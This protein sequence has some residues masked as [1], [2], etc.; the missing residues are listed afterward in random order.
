MSAFYFVEPNDSLFVR[1]NQAFG[2]AGEY[3]P[4]LMPPPPSLFA[5]AFRAAILGQDPQ[6]LGRFSTTGATADRELDAVLGSFHSETGEVVQPGSFGL[7]WISLASRRADSDG[8][9]VEP[10]FPLAADLVK[11]ES[12]FSRLTPE[13][14]SP[15][16][17]DGRDLPAVAVLRASKQSKP[18]GG[19]YL[20]ALGWQRHLADELPEL[21]SQVI[22]AAALYARDPRLGIGLD[23]A[24]GTV[25]AGLIYTT[26][27]YAFSPTESGRVAATGF[28]IGIEGADDRLGETGFLRLGGDGRGARYQR[29]DYRPPAPPTEALARNRRFRLVL[30]T[31]GLFAHGW[32]PTGVHHEGMQYVLKA[33]GCTAR[34]VCAAVPRREVISGWNLFRWQPK[35]AERVAPAGSVYWFE[36][37]NGPVDKLAAW[38]AAG[39]WDDTAQAQRRA[40]G[41][42]LAWLGAWT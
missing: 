21:P 35:D 5:G 24:A 7:S 41:Y 1:G 22:P 23:S 19:L 29:V 10:V 28:L 20:S 11:L 39:L 40:E 15:L 42:N 8:L 34:L 4:S 9:S 30:G 36:D 12:G 37:L 31:P 26:E 13:P 32:L 3:G 14:S 17:S 38:V 27:G 16:I 18:E 25:Q 33:A 6:A 2:D